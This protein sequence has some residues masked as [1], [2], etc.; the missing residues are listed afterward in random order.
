MSNDT[1]P[2]SI[3]FTHITVQAIDC[4]EKLH[5]MKYRFNKKVSKEAALRELKKAFPGVPFIPGTVKVMYE[6]KRYTM[7]IEDF[8]RFAN[9]DEEVSTIL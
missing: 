1:F 4:T 9:E 7:R 5:T 8:M 6:T 2:K 3:T